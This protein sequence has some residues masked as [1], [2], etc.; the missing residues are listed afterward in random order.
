MDMFK[1]AG[2]S[3]AVNATRRALAAS[4][5]YRQFSRYT[6]NLDLWLIRPPLTCFITYPLDSLSVRT[7]NLYYAYSHTNEHGNMLRLDAIEG[8]HLYEQELKYQR[9]HV[10]VDEE[11]QEEQQGG[12]SRRNSKA[13]GAGAAAA[14]AA[15]GAAA[16]AREAAGGAGAG[17]A[18]AAGASGA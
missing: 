11:Q 1:T 16:G 12:G 8:V 7:L 14:A 5:V 15:A 18:A 6:Q 9:A 13:A 17:G 2:T 3:N 10:N 4:T